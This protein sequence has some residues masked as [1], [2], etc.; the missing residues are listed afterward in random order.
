MGFLDPSDKPRG[1]GACG[2]GVGGW[3][4]SP[5]VLIMALPKSEQLTFV[6]PSIKR[7]E[8][9]SHRFSGYSTF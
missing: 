7:A 5:C 9:I 6:A 1:V 2:R 3:Y 8:I 4:A